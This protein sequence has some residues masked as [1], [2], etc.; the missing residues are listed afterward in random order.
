MMKRI[1]RSSASGG[2]AVGGYRVY[3]D[4]ETDAGA[5]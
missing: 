1:K 5:G 2:E 3:I 4:A